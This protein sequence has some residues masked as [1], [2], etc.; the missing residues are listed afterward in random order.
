MTVK[1][2]QINK[3][4]ELFLAKPY[5]IGM[6]AGNLSKRFKCDRRDIYEVRRIIKERQSEADEKEERALEL[7]K[8]LIFDIETSP[9]EA[10]VFQTQVW[11]AR[12]SPDMILSQ[13]FMLT[14]SA[15]WLFSTN[16]MSNRLTSE[17]VKNEDDG[18]IVKDLWKLFDEADMIVAHNG[19]MFDVPNMN[20]RFLVNGMTPP[21]AYRR[22]DTLK[23]ARKEFGFTHNALDALASVLGLD[24]KLK[25]NFSLWKR[26]KTGE[27]KALIEMEIYN[28][29]DVIL[30]EE[31]YLKLRPW[32]RSHPNVGLYMDTEDPICPHCGS[33]D[34]KLESHSYYTNAGK[35]ETYRCQCGAVSRKRKSVLSKTKNKNMLVPIPR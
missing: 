24:G 15:K 13:W 18:R 1:Q 27:E 21:S 35:Y 20:T 4:V 16:T 34:V 11:K 32:I 2:E 31:V 30:L 12:I 10:F 9:L 23:V 28:V 26:C 17:E 22:I 29:Q 6:G 8:I 19:D 3:L 25:T 5:L 14:W 7:P 33:K